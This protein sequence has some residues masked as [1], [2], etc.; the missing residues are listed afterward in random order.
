MWT[1]SELASTGH[2]SPYISGVWLGVI[3]DEVDSYHLDRDGAIAQGIAN[4][5][6]PWCHATQY[7]NCQLV[8]GGHYQEINVNIEDD[9]PCSN[10]VVDIRTAQLDQSKKRRKCFAH[11]RL[12]NYSLFFSEVEVEDEAYDGEGNASCC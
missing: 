1:W 10:E 6:Q 2:S 12:V 8:Y 9:S 3:E 11:T 4:G 7:L 5:R